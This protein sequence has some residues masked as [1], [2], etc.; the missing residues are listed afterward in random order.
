MRSPPP[1]PSPSPPPPWASTDGVTERQEEPATAAPASAPSTL[2]PT[3]APSSRTPRGATSRP[4][5][6]GRLCW[7]SRPACGFS[8]VSPLPCSAL[9]LRGLAEFSSWA[10]AGGAG[11]EFRWFCSAI[12]FFAC[13]ALSSLLALP[14]F[15]LICSSLLWTGLNRTELDWTGLD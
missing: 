5:A 11:F 4:S 9:L 2:R 12:V 8:L 15:S 13:F 3:T 6:C 10:V 14:R 1:P 7:P